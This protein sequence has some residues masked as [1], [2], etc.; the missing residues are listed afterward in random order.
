MKEENGVY[1][2]T[3]EKQARIVLISWLSVTDGTDHK[4]M[5][6]PTLQPERFNFLVGFYGTGDV[7]VDFEMIAKSFKKLE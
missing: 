2:N 3:F 7:V 4:R 6:E 1:S 5:K